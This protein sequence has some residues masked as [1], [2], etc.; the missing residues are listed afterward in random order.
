MSE[1]GLIAFLWLGAILVLLLKTE[2]SKHHLAFGVGLVASLLAALLPLSSF[3]EDFKQSWQSFFGILS[4]QVDPLAASLAFL[5]T[6]IGTVCIL[7]SW[8]YMAG[9]P[10]IGRYYAL[11]LFF[12]GAMLGLVLSNSFFQLFFFWELTALCSY[13]LIAFESDSPAAVEGGVR[14]L[15]ITQIGGLGLL[16][17]ALLVY[18]QS[19]SYEIGQFLSDFPSYPESLKVILAFGI[20]AAV[21][22]KSAQVPF[23]TWLSGAME[24]P[25]PVSAL[26]HAATM[27]NAGV[28]VL[29]RLYP[30]FQTVAYWKE[31]VITLALLS[32]LMAALMALASWDIKALLAYSTISQLAYMVYAIGFGDLAAAQLHLVSHALFKALLFLSAG[33]IIHNLGTRDMRQMGGLWHKMPFVRNTVLI[34]TAGLVGIPI[35][36]GFWSKELIL[37]AALKAG[38]WTY[39]LMLLGLALTTAYSVRMLR[40]LLTGNAKSEPKHPTSLAMKFSLA[41]LAFG[42]LTS[43]LPLSSAQ[44]INAYPITNSESLLDVLFNPATYLAL[45]VIA[46]ASFLAHK[47]ENFAKHFD[48]LTTIFASE[49]GFGSLN[50]R[51]QRLIQGLSAVLSQGQTGILS[52]NL[53]AVFLALIILLLLK[54][55]LL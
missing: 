27:V 4:F 5:A 43:W 33:A 8:D 48:R 19:G 37:D 39:W 2:A 14:A 55:A 36:N 26:I 52:W 30:A 15:I 24:A 51:L 38:S 54:G 46:V 53:V 49:F 32:A 23:H 50:Q 21:A 22:A 9:E 1:L 35:T 34:G 40:L 44:E 16:F 31:T 45:T 25:T 7:F 6:S 20:L 13:A 41:F 10:Q 29:I 12:I 47:A 18:Q 28:Y 11:I 3:N 17:T 42:V